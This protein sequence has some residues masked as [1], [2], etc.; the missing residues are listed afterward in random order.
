MSSEVRILSPAFFNM[1]DLESI[2]E[3]DE[4]HLAKQI[5]T[6]VV[7][8]GFQKAFVGTPYSHI[9]NK[10]TREDNFLYDYR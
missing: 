9:I 3:E 5:L 8:S 4:Y 2:F 10:L 6:L 7:T 1:K